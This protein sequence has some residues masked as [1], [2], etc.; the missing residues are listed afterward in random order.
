MPILDSGFRR[1]DVIPVLSVL[2]DRAKDG[3]A[4]FLRDGDIGEAPPQAV[5][6]ALE[7]VGGDY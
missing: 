1:N 6:K 3:D 7:V 4:A 5:R 2:K